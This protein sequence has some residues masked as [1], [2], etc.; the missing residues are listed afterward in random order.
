MYLVLGSADHCWYVGV[1]LFHH[2]GR[3]WWDPTRHQSLAPASAVEV[4]VGTTKAMVVLPQRSSVDRVL[5]LAQPAVSA[6][7]DCSERECPRPVHTSHPASP[8]IRWISRQ[9]CNT[10]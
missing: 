7:S 3:G 6:V 8:P 5:C 2:P 1:C 9:P 10:T 4:R